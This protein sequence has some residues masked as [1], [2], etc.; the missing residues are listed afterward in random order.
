MLCMVAMIRC[1]F[2]RDFNHWLMGRLRRMGFS[3][4]PETDPFRLSVRFFEAF[5]RR[6]QAKPREVKIS[7]TLTRKLFGGAIPPDVHDTIETIVG[8]SLAGKSLVPFQTA[9]VS[10]LDEVDL[11]LSDW[12]IH[13]LHVGSVRRSRKVRRSLRRRGARPELHIEGRKELLF[14][15]VS[16]DA[17]HLLDLRDHDAWTDV[18]LLEIVLKDWPELLESFA[19]RGVRAAQALLP[20]ERKVLRSKHL[21]TVVELSNGQCYAPPGGG[22]VSSGASLTAVRLAIRMNRS[23][24]G[25]QQDIIASE[26]DIRA[27]LAEIG[28]NP[29]ILDL[30]LGF[31][32]DFR[33]VLHE[34]TTGTE[35][36]TQLRLSNS[37]VF[38]DDPALRAA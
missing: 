35:V 34:K 18:G 15:W 12:N 1:D 16:D 7:E 36:R 4:A 5:R 2:E 20:A 37:C 14:V 32:D 33:V 21:G 24:A 27:R 8:V 13:H 9:N 6:I 19:L 26:K 31:D 29:D 3:P 30:E 22:Y 23:L 17:V 10:I 25:L 38:E 11:M 28:H